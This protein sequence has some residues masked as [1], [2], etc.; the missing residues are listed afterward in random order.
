[1]A[2][3][4]PGGL[5]QPGAAPEAAFAG[6]AP[7]A[8]SDEDNVLDGRRRQA[9]PVLTPEEIARLRRFG[10]VRTWPPGALLFEAGKPGPGMFV[11]LSGRVRIT[12]RDGLGHDAPVVEQGPGE[13]L[14]EVGQLSGRPALVDA[15]AVGSVEALLIPPEG[16]RA[17]VVAEADLGE[18]IMR[19]LI[20][21]RVS[22]IESGTG[23][24]VLIAPFGTPDLVELANFLAR[25]GHPFTV[26]DPAADHE[27]AVLLEHYARGG[28]EAGAKG[29]LPL[30]V[31][32]DGTALRDP[33]EAELARR[34]GL[35]AEWTPD[36]VH[37]VAV[38]GA[39]P[40]GLA[41][42]Y[43]SSEGLSVLVLEARAFGG[44]AGASARIENYLGFPTGISGQA[45][46]GRAFVQAQKFGTK[47]AV[48]VAAR[49]LDCGARQREGALALEL[50]DG[51]RALGRAVIVA[52][53]AVYR[54]PDVPDLARFEGRGVRYWASPV[55]ARLC[56]QREVALVGGGNSA[57]QAAVFL[58]AHAARVHMLVRGDGLAESMSQYLVE[59]IAAQPNIEVH[60]RTAV[61]GL[62]GDECGLRAVRWRDGAGQET[63]RPIR[64]IFLFV[65]ADPCT[66]WLAE[67][68]VALDDKGFVR[69]GGGG[70]ALPLETSLP[71]VFAIGDVRAGSTKR[72]A[73]A[74]GEGAEA[75]A[76]VHAHL[77][78]EEAE[79]QAHRP[80][81]AS[82]RESAC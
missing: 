40:A 66:G 57:G 11:I 73:A 38:V 65:G 62:E 6:A 17:L 37:D 61:V 72:V 59:R 64:N 55:E 18:R 50:E 76:Q 22:L 26:L 42:V 15:H 8:A 3:A 47:V 56:R 60:V 54:R 32:P 7:D 52:S 13:F 34:L 36:Q 21:R 9:F 45:L 71:G 12:R 69:T 74:V 1:V 4:P 58:A 27:A 20:L 49:R 77:A 79:Q 68:G 10:E 29:G 23:G 70:G 5:E 67:C 53:G 43:A 2:E 35:S 28:A 33:S 31:L 39:G 16:L 48:P 24:P 19:A 63:R 80:Q 30:V 82:V 81:R 46:M 41:A 75:V 25:N 78:R 14:A 51:R 44:Q